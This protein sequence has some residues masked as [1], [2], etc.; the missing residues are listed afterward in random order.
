MLLDVYLNQTSFFSYLKKYQLIYR[1]N[2]FK[3]T[4]TSWSDHFR[5]ACYSPALNRLSKEVE[6]FKMEN[7]PY[8]VFL[9]IRIT[10]YIFIDYIV[11]QVLYFCVTEGKGGIR[12]LHA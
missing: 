6:E 7:K 3:N 8:L 4:H 1:V 2:F 9:Y 11:Y 12:L 10:W 5:L